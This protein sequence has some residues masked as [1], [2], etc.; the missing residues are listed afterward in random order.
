MPVTLDTHT[1]ASLMP[2]RQLGESAF[3]ASIEQ[4]SS[5]SELRFMP[6][7]DVVPWDG[8]LDATKYGAACPANK[9]ADGGIV[10]DLGEYSEDCLTVNVFVGDRC[11]A[12][13][14]CAVL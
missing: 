13:G 10:D 5:R 4:I 11:R 3:G 8:V 12:L 1:S 14:S 6:P 7:A 2:L 9:S